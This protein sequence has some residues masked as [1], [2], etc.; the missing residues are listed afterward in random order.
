MLAMWVILGI[1]VREVPHCEK[2]ACLLVGRQF[3]DA[4]RHDNL[5]ADER[6]AELSLR[7]RMRSAGLRSAMSFIAVLN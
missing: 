2:D 5:A 7:S 6:R 3:R 4:W 1:E